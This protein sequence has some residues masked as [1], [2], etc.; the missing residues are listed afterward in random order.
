M[1]GIGSSAKEPLPPSDGERP[2]ISFTF[3]GSTVYRVRGSDLFARS[4]YS[5]FLEIGSVA[6]KIPF[7]FDPNFDSFWTAPDGSA[8]L[9]AK[10]GRNI[11][12]YPLGIDDYGSAGAA[13]L[14]Y[15]MLPPFLFQTPGA[16]VAIRNRDAVRL[17]PGRLRPI[18]PRVSFEIALRFADGWRLGFFR[19][20]CALRFAG[21]VVA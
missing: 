3:G 17:V 21:G 2:V 15:L 10:G 8:V 1:N 9:L 19:D 16:V 12:Y 20:F 5:D 18:V 14:P 6:G 11:F 7:E 4:L 13:S